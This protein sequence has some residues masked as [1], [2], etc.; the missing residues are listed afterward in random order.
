MRPDAGSSSFWQDRPVFVTGA[1]GLIGGWLVKQLLA[2][3]ADVVC[4]LRDWVPQSELVRSDLLSQVKVVRGDIR[5][6]ELLL[7]ALG[8][9]EISTVMHLAAQSIVNVANREPAGTLD[10]NMRGTWCLLDA[11][12]RTPSVKG[13]VLA[14]TDK[15]YGEVDE[16][17]YHEGMPLLAKYPHDVSKAG[18][19]MIAQGYAATYGT[20]TG[21]LRLPNIFGGGDLN[22]NRIIPGTIR[23]VLR[24][25]APV[26]QS[27]G[28]F[29]RDYLYVEDTA[30][31]HLLLAQK[32]SEQPELRGEAFNLSSETRLTVV[33]L[34]ERILKLMD[35]DLQPEIQNRAKQEIKSQYMSAAKM[36]ERLG[37]E[38]LF[39]MDEGLGRTI[40]WYRAYFAAKSND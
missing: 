7:R 19:E 39:S 31:A 18:A 26:I 16:L 11:C 25:Q 20:P 2:L 32:L 14:S 34:V 5:D 10:T 1:S 15:V 33:E 4:L 9:Y 8:E 13:I 29:I 37:W 27:D 38:P 22:W 3:G 23:S 30:A 35:S 21:M 28:K 12:R 6:P 17:P 24:G 36:R 40:E